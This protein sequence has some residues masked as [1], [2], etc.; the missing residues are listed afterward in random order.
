MTDLIIY[1]EF[2]DLIPPL[3]DD[4]KKQLE[5]NI[6]R[7]GIQDPLKVWSGILIDGHNRYEIAK[8][9]GLEFKTVEMQFDS[10]DDVKIWIIQNQLGRRNINDY[11]RGELVTQFKAIIAA[12][13]KENQKLSDGRGKKGLSNLANLNGVAEQ[14]NGEEFSQTRPINTRNELAKMADVSTGTMAKIE[15]LTEEASPEIK[16]ALR[17][18]DISISA[19][20]EG[21]KAGATTVDEVVAVKES[22]KPHVYFNNGNNEWYTPAEFIEAARKTLG[23]IDLDPASSKI[24]NETVKATKFFTAEDDGLAQIWEGNIWLNPPYSSG[25]IEKFADKLVHSDYTAAIVLVNNSTDTEWFSWL[26]EIADAVIFPK[27]RVKF[28]K[29]DGTPG[30]PLQGQAILYFGNNVEAFKENF[31]KYGRCWQ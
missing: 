28:L 20:F 23:T 25:L 3:S 16:S 21:I 4:E 9:H 1:K 5:E 26:A 11:T 2:H 8:R 6:L 14:E 18:G 12:R 22:K 13:A 17:T 10:R 31:G 19:A 29:P 15:T 27:G 30:A 7:D 24:A